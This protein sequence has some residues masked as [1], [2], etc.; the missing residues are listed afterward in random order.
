VSYLLQLWR[1]LQAILL[2]FEWMPDRVSP[3]EPI[4]RFIFYRD[5]VKSGR[6][7]FAAFMPSAKSHD[8]SVYRI[9]GCR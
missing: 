4:C 7:S 2:K 3:H 8:V 6:V 1:F 9:R 5:H